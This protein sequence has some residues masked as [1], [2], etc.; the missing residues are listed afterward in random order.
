MS[1]SERAPQSR[2]HLRLPLRPP[3]SQEIEKSVSLSET[4]RAFREIARWTRR[5]GYDQYFCGGEVV[6]AFCEV[7]RLLFRRAK[8]SHPKI[9]ADVL[10][11]SQSFHENILD[12]MV[13]V[14]DGIEVFGSSH[15][16]ELYRLIDIDTKKMNQ[17][18][19]AYVEKQLAIFDERADE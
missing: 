15:L 4:R 5:D 12:E 18:D 10:L 17:S 13:D 8:N 14:R 3:F 2:A 1:A 9:L 6:A 19:R 7:M 11:E 16:D